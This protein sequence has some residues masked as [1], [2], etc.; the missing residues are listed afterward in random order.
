MFQGKRKAVTFSYDDGTVQDRRLIALFDKYALKGT[1]HL[2]SERMGEQDAL[3]VGER[4]VDH[5]RIPA[6]QIAK[7]YAGH[8]VAG[9]TLTHPNLYPLTDAQI[10]HQVEQD[11]RNLSKLVG[12]DVVGFAYAGM[13]EENYSDRVVKLLKEQTGVKYARIV[14]WTNDFRFD[15]SDLYRYQANLCHQMNP[16][17]FL[18]YGRKFVESRS[19]APQLLCVFGHSYHLD[20]TDYWWDVMEEFC[21][22]VSG[23]EDVF[24]GTLRQ[25]LLEE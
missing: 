23:Q 24:Y 11:R 20:S 3:T 1:F 21:A 5:S 19:D 10:V 4:T 25:I 17:A 12:Y 2:N 6:E 15:R 22:T 7:V 8:E 14:P 13:S 18:E 16:K 9:H